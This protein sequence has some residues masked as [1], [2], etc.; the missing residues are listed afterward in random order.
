MRSSGPRRAVTCGN[1]HWCLWFFF[2]LRG[3]SKQAGEQAFTVDPP[4]GCY[5]SKSDW[6]FFKVHLNVKLTAS[7]ME[8][9]TN[10]Q[11]T[12]GI[13]LILR[14][15]DDGFH[16]LFPSWSRISRIHTR[17]IKTQEEKKKEEDV[18][19]WNES[20]T[21]KEC[22]LFTSK[23]RVERMGETRKKDGTKHKIHKSHK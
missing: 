18:K 9:A 21:W 20:K 7:A 15:Q 11:L 10:A 1:G 17:A 16:V 8:I 2:L 3:W 5:Q 14:Q 12:R 13:S 23:S 6:K 22:G 4:L 19:E